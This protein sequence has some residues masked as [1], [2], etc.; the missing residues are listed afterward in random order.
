MTPEAF[1]QALRTAHGANL[2]SVTL[3]GSGAT[4]DRDRRWSDYNILVVRK[5]PDVEGLRRAAGAVRAWQR[6]G[7]PPP[8]TMTAAFLRN[9]ADVFPLEWLDM[10]DAREVLAG[11]DV[12]KAVKVN[13]ANLRAELERELKVGLLRFNAALQGI[14]WFGRKRALRDLLVRTASA[15]EVLLRGALRLLNVTPLPAKRDAVVSLATRWRFD[16]APFAFAA[17]LKAGDAAAKR[18][19]PWPWIKRLASSVESVIERVDKE[20]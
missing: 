19:D 14:G 7:N 9:S 2:V 12:L 10:A 18:Q 8:V 11:R 16:P 3:Y 17:R 4:G 5:R 20:A 1:A 6:A 15:Y 13:R